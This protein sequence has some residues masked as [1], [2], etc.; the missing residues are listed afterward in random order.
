MVE[1]I[2]FFLA[3][4]KSISMTNPHFIEGHD[5][6]VIFLMLAAVIKI[7]IRSI[8]ILIIKNTIFNTAVKEM[9]VDTIEAAIKLKI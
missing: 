8:G 2:H 3:I 4:L 9:M 5:S 6:E 1:S 7:P